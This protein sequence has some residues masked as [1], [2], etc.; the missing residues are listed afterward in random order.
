MDVDIVR[1]GSDNKDGECNRCSEE[2]LWKTPVKVITE[3]EENVK[4]SSEEDWLRRK[5]L[6][7]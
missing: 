2:A 5:E 7:D 3:M 4:N 1:Q 6:C